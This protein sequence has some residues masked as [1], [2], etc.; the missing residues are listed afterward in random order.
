MDKG[1]R[2]ILFYGKVNDEFCDSD[3][4]LGNINFMLWRYFK[5]QGYRRIVFFD[6]ASKITFYDPESKRL[7]LPHAD[8]KSQTSSILKGPLGRRKLWCHDSSKD[9]ADVSS[10]AGRTAPGSSSSGGNGPPKQ[11]RMSDL[12]ALEILDFIMKRDDASLPTVVI[13]SLAEDIRHFQQTGFREMQ[14][15]LIQ[16]SRNSSQRTHKCVFIF[17]QSTLEEVKEVTR[18]HELH[19]VANFIREKGNDTSNMVGIGFP[20]EQ[21]ITNLIHRYRLRSGLVVNWKILGKTAQFLANQRLSM[22]NLNSIFSNVRELNKNTLHTWNK[23]KL[24]KSTEYLIENLEKEDAD[25]PDTKA[26]T[27]KLSSV[28]CQED[29]IAQLIDTLDTWYAR[30]KKDKPLSFFLGGTSGVGKTYTVELLAEALSHLG[31]EYCYFAMNEFSQEH[32]VSNLIGSPRGYVGSE[33]E[34]KLFAA[35]N[36]S[37]RLVILFDEIEKAHERI[38]T[39]LMQLLDKGFLS[40]NK[41]EGD[42]RECIV[43]FT[44]NA[45]RQEMTDLKDRFKKRGKSTAEPEFQNTVRDILVQANVAPEVCGRI[46]KFLVYNPLTHEAMVQITWQ[47]TKKLAQSYGLEIVSIAP[48]F[49]AEVAAKATNPQYGARSAQDMVAERLGK[50]LITIKKNQQKVNKVT[51]VKEGESYKALSA[52]EATGLLPVEQ[53]FNRA[54]KLIS[55]SAGTAQNIMTQP[56]GK[57]RR[58]LHLRH[59]PVSLPE[60]SGSQLSESYLMNQAVA[61]VAYVEVRQ[62]DGKEA[63]GS[64]FA[65]TADGK[66]ITSYHVVEGAI[67]I[68]VRLDNRP[69]RWVNAEFFDGDEEAD[70][71]VL[72][73]QGADFPYALLAPYGD[74]LERGENVALL[75]YPLGEN[76]ADTVTYTGGVISNFKQRSTGVS[77]LQIDANAY[78]GSSGGPL[79]RLRDGR[80]IGIL[81]GGWKEATQVNFAVS[82]NELYKRLLCEF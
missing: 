43:C 28:Y 60:M 27:D 45:Q 69:E 38:F 24:I 82:I 36:R 33:E 77:L 20:D 63:S 14:N 42:F 10:Q 34:P 32:T 44:S 40:W 15:R 71:A 37:Q 47:E 23:A 46:N 81:M 6:G 18:S 17:Q 67:S 8:S 11:S 66:F 59:L 53:I 61:A 22:A 19:G 49:L 29:N 68:R 73:L 7:C 13:F 31:Y 72:N 21:E 3:L 64:G 74:K 16:W 79:V 62:Q 76:L 9:T 2:F 75:G 30:A 51:V 70:I 4:V 50:T 25:M 56:M 78:H 41:G 26:L 12:S 52:H 57:P 58:L 5:R 55:T 1:D 35:L 80:V 39:A 54:T 65:I 48:E